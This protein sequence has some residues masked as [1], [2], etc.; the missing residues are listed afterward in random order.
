MRDSCDHCWA[1]RGMTNGQFPNPGL[2]GTSLGEPLIL[3]PYFLL[4]CIYHFYFLLF[5]FYILSNIHYLSRPLKNNSQIV[6]SKIG[7]GDLIL[8]CN[9]FSTYTSEI[10]F[11]IKTCSRKNLIWQNNVSEWKLLNFYHA[12]ILRVVK[13]IK[14][15]IGK[16]WK[17]T[18]NNSK[19]LNLGPPGFDLFYFEITH[20]GWAR[21]KSE[22]K[23]Q[24]CFW[25]QPAFNWIGLKAITISRSNG[26]LFSV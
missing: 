26:L 2:N 25:G 8:F 13:I 22:R 23:G 7:D 21:R 19:P 14:I 1:E 4:K 9:S 16:N 10:S 15:G 24:T 5:I 18:E 20:R 6:H 12:E 11:G 3:E 17:N